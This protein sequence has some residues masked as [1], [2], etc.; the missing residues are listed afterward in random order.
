MSVPSSDLGPFHPSSVSECV[1]PLGH[2]GEEQHF[3]ARQGGPIWTTGK[4]AWHSVYSV[5]GTYSTSKHS[6]L[7]LNGYS[8]GPVPFNFRH[9]QL[10]STYRQM[11]QLLLQNHKA[12]FRDGGKTVYVNPSILPT[13]CFKKGRKIGCKAKKI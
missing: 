12:N 9:T 1:S 10:P 13:Q 2:K 7:Q 11:Q 3:L 4:K 8:T 5:D 6:S